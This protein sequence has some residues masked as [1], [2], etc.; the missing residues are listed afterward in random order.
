MKKWCFVFFLLLA[1]LQAKV[2]DCFI[3]F[4]E[5]DVLQIR[6][7]E[8]YDHV[9]KFV[10][11]ESAMSH[12]GLKKLYNLENNWDRFAKYRDKIVYLKMDTLQGE[13]AGSRENC[14]K[15]YAKK[16]LLENGKDDDL[17][18]FSDADEIPPASS[19]EFAKQLIETNPVIAF[20]QKMYRHFLNRKA[21]D[22]ED[23]IGTIGIQLRYLKYAPAEL[24]GL[25]CRICFEKCTDVPG[26]KPR[27]GKKAKKFPYKLSGEKV[28]VPLIKGGWH[29]SYMGG[30]AN[31]REKVTHW[32]HWENPSPQ[33]KQAW[34][35]EVFM[36]PLVE[37]DE[38]YPQFVRDNKAHFKE[39]GL[40][41]E[42]RESA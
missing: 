40:I 12:R 21:P 8:L 1:S 10:I 34:E 39:I 37:I 9:D 33:T 25:R 18:L 23:W 30:Y 13:C 31:F 35:G 6:L 41:D 27:T 4:N 32:I 20:E 16:W 5:F 22:S 2:Y 19:I 24:N 3:F 15:N 38:S 36:H 42:A 28:Q 26:I 17:V 14:Q 11:V 29:F 7:E